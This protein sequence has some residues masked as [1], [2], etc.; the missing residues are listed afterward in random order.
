MAPDTYFP[1]TRIARGLAM[2]KTHAERQRDYRDRQA[3]SRDTSHDILL[4]ILSEL[5]SLR[6]LVTRH[7][8]L[9][10]TPLP[11]SPSDS[12]NNYPPDPPLEKGKI[13]PIGV[14]RARV[15]VRPSIEEWQ[16]SEAHYGLSEQKGLSAGEVDE[17]AE[18]YL[19]WMRSTGK[20]HKDLNA[21]FRNWLKT[22]R[23][24]SHVNGRAHQ[25]T[26]AEN[27]FEGG[28]RAAIAFDAR[29][30]RDHLSDEPLLEG[31]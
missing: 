26:A 3:A 13:T 30:A 25:P 17:Q 15:L 29:I 9:P 12:P 6:D 1:P 24:T 10:L 23:T 31:E 22:E 14:T 4:K 2:A 5:K 11:S 18:S 27:L 16:P 19:D 20:R 28:Y 21:G 8:T 7:V